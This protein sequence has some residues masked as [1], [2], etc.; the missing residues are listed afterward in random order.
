MAHATLLHTPRVGPGRVGATGGRSQGRALPPAP[1]AGTGARP[2]GHVCAH[3]QGRSAGLGAHGSCPP[4]STPAPLLPCPFSS[5]PG[6]GQPTVGCQ[7]GAAGRP[8]RHCDMALLWVRAAL[9]W[10]CRPL[11]SF[12]A[13]PGCCHTLSSRPGRLPLHPR[14]SGSQR[15]VSPRQRGYLPRDPPHPPLAFSTSSASWEG[16]GQDTRS[17][18]RLPTFLTGGMLSTLGL[19]HQGT[20]VA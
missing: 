14:G 19:L 15:Q 17:S 18:R 12:S 16:S 13:T 8:R 4:T 2:T 1:C 11:G 7:E 9:P 5:R 20:S 10:H 6:S 3:A